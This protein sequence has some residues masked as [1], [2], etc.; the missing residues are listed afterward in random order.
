MHVFCNVPASL[1]CLLTWL[2]N[3]SIQ[4]QCLCENKD[5][6]HAHKQLWLLCIGTHSGVS[7]NA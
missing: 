4:R 2:T 5:E 6:N 7:H 1:A 3:Q